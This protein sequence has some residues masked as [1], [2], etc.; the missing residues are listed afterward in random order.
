MAP[1]N[2]ASLTGINNHVPGE[3]RSAI[4]RCCQTVV[5]AVPS[6]VGT[7]FGAV[8]WFLLYVLMTQPRESINFH[9]W[10]VEAQLMFPYAFVCLSRALL[11]STL[12]MSSLFSLCLQGPE[13]PVSRVTCILSHVAKGP[14]EGDT[15]AHLV[16]S[17]GNK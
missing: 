16:G 11:G 12:A 6:H 14:E 1:L 9:F 5:N 2:N 17:K 8:P 3:I 15:A 10:A 13:T 7:A 4:N